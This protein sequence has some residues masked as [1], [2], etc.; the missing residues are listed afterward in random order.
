VDGGVYVQMDEQGIP[1]TTGKALK[2]IWLKRKGKQAF[3]S[4]DDTNVFNSLSFASALFTML[5]TDTR[6]NRLF[7]IAPA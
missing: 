5:Y 7:E 6:A 1:S 4:Y 2:P 3:A